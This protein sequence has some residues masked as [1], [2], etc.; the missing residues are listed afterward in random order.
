MV[1]CNRLTLL[2]RDVVIFRFPHPVQKQQTLSFPAKSREAEDCHATPVGGVDQK[3]NHIT[4]GARNDHYLL[5]LML[6]RSGT[7]LKSQI[8]T[9]RTF[10]Y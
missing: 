6:V 5:E 10:L 9:Q 4:G 2:R 3:C 7:M 1:G 8:C